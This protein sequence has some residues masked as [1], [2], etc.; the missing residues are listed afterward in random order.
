MVLYA[1]RDQINPILNSG[2]RPDDVNQTIFKGGRF[3]SQIHPSKD[4]PCAAV[5]TDCQST[6]EKPHDVRPYDLERPQN[7]QPHDFRDTGCRQRFEKRNRLTFCLATGTHIA[8][9]IDGR[10][11]AAVKESKMGLEVT[12]DSK[13]FRETAAREH[14]CCVG[15]H[16]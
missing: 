12:L 7:L 8:S 2:L 4:C 9:G 5:G 15:A 14:Q 16:R 1:F 11:W 6:D 13:V 10:V 3:V